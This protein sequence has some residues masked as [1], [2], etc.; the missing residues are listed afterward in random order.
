MDLGPR[1]RW[2]MPKRNQ[3]QA[4]GDHS[5]GDARSR[6]SRRSPSEGARNIG[7]AVA[8]S[9]RFIALIPVQIVR[10]VLLF[11]AAIEWLTR[12]LARSIAGA[13]ELAIRAIHSGLTPVRAGAVA[14]LVA[15]GVL[16]ASQF[17]DFRAVEIGQAGYV[18]AEGSVAAPLSDRQAPWDAHGASVLVLGVLAAL[19]ALGA[20]VS[21]SRQR[22]ISKLLAPAAVAACAAGLAVSF[23]VDLPK[24]TDAGAAAGAYSHAEPVL[25]NT[26][27]AQVAALSVLAAIALLPSAWQNGTQTAIRGKTGRRPRTEPAR[28]D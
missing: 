25:L 5:R 22:R 24:G 1:L 11:A 20:I 15:V 26:F 6:P 4:A 23:G 28:A 10:G 27:F 12:L 2:R 17:M 9:V 3:R 21:R 13:A 16:A 8:R 18:G 14:I 7:S 19:L